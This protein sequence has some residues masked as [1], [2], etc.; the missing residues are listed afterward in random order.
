[1]FK[2][3]RERE[4]EGV[5]CGKIDSRCQIHSGY[6]LSINHTCL[7]VIEIPLFLGICIHPSLQINVE[8]ICAY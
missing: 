2:S 1:M 4:R 5:G 6:Q 3:L 7:R 8:C